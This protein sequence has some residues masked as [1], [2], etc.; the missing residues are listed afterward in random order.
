MRPGK[1]LRGAL[2]PAGGP[3]ASRRRSDETGFQAA[4]PE[5]ALQ[6]GGILERERANEE[7]AGEQKV[8]GRLRGTDRRQLSADRMAGFR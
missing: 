4:Q 6:R 5:L 3:E 1:A 2:A 7:G 8:V